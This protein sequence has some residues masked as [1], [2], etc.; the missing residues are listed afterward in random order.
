MTYGPVITDYHTLAHGRPAAYTRAAALA[1]VEELVRESRPT[2]VY[3][4]NSADQHPDHKA[5]YDL[6]RAA[7]AAI[8]FRGIVLTFVVHSGLG[9]PWPLGPTP[10]SPFESRTIGGTTYPI[11]VLWPPPIRTPLTEAQSALKL[12]VVDAYH[13][14]LWSPIDRL[15]LESFVKSDEVFWTAQ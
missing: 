7:I 12:Q 2:Q 5:T 9:W 10:D 3:V 4:T 14:Q 8:G 13:S 11:G 6:V 15:Y 1:D